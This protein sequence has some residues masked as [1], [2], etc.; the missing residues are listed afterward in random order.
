MKRDPDRL[1]NLCLLHGWRVETRPA[2][3]VLDMGRT[4]KRA[5]RHMVRTPWRATWAEVLYDEELI[6][7]GWDQLMRGA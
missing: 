6:D 7:D 1:R 3:T 2:G 5:S 4:M